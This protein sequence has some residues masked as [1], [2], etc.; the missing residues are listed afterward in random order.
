VTRTR[1]TPEDFNPSAC[2]TQAGWQ[3]HKR[4]QVPACLPCTLASG[5]ERAARRLRA[6]RRNVKHGGT[7]AYRKLGCRCPICVDA[8]RDWRAY[9]ALM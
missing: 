2:G 7:I 8:N 9:V 6:Q 5:V 3:R 4:A 1:M